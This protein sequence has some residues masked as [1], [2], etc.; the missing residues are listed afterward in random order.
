MA[1]HIS[2]LDALKSVLFTSD[3]KLFGVRAILA[4]AFTGVT[5]YLWAAGD[6]VPAE[7]LVITSGID[8]F[9]FG[10][11]VAQSSNGS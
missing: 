6:P 5:V 4:F 11:R 8:S 3:G 10:S 7:L 1:D 9:Y 2:F